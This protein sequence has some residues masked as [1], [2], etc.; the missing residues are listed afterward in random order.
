MKN[1]FYCI[2][3]LLIIAGLNDSVIAQTPQ[4]YNFNVN[5]SNNSFPTNIAG[6]KDVQLLYLAGNFNQPGPAPAGNIVSIALRIADTYP[7]GPW[8]YTNFTIQ[9]GQSVITTFATGTF[10]TGTLT[11]VY[12]HATVTLTGAA[13]QWMTIPLDTPFPYDPT[14]SLIVDIGQCS[15]PAA[16]GYSMCFSASTGLRRN[17]SAGGCPFAYSSQDNSIYHMGIN[18]ATGGP[19]VVVT[20]AAT[21]VTGN[22]ANLNGTVNANG[23]STSVTFDYGLTTSYGTNV[24][25]VPPTV[26]GNTVTP[27]TV[28]IAGLA[29]NTTYHYRVNGVNSFGTT[30]GGDMTF[31]TLG[32]PPTVVTT[33]A[34][35]VT[36]TSATLNG[37]V[38]ANNVSTS[39]SFDYGLNTSYGTNVAGVPPTVTGNVATA[40]LANI[41]GLAGN[42]TYHYRINGTSSNGTT[43][44]NDM[45]FTTSGPPP[46]VVT[47]A[48]TAVTGTTATLNGTVNAN[49]V[50]STVMFEWGPTVAYG[51][52]INGI[53]PTVSGNSVTPVSAPIAGLL[54]GNTYHFRV[55]AFNTN[56]TSYGNDMSLTTPTLAPTVITYA[57]TAIN[58]TVATLN[59]L[60]TANGVSTNIFFDYGLTVA[61]GTIVAGVPPSVAGNTPTQSSYNLTG[62]TNGT[63]YHYRARGVNSNG[64]TNGNDVTFTTGCFSAGPAGPVTGPT[65]VCQG[66]SGYVYSVSPI[67]NASGYIWTLPVGGTITLGA[68]TNTITVSY[69]ASAVSGYVYVYGIAGCGNGSPAQLAVAMNPPAAPTITGPASV[70]VNSTPVVYSTQSGMSAYAWSVSPGG[71]ITAGLGTSTITVS[72]ATVGAKTV[73]VNYNTAAGCSALSPTVYNVTVNALPIPTIAGPSPA[74]SNYPGLIYSTQAGM[75]S[76]NWNISAGG[77]ITAGAGTNTIT[78]TWN[79]IGAQTISVNYANANGCTAA[80]PVVYPVTVNSGAA[81]TI[82]GTTTL[83]VNSGYYN[84]T[85]QAGNSGY[86][87]TISSGGVI[88]FGAGTNVITVTWT[89]SGAQWVRVNYTTPA[90]CSAVSP[91]QYNVTVNAPPAAAGSITGT[92]TVCAGASNVVYTVAPVQGAS[93][94]VWTLPAGATNANGSS[95][96]SIL[97]NFAGNASSGN[98]TVYANNLCGNGATSPPFAVTV[99]PLPADAGTITGP[100]SVCQGATGAVYTVTPITGSTGYA[101]TVPAGATI[102]SGGNTNSIVVD[103]GLGAVSGNIT[104]AGTNAC[105]NGVVSPNFPVTVNAIPTTP[106]VTNT[107]YI[108]HSS[109]PTGNQWWYSA[110]Q[111]GTGAPIAGATAQTYDATLT[112]TGWYWSIV[113]LNGCSSA[114]SNHLQVITTGIGSHSSSAINIYPVP[115]NGQFNVTITTA[116]IESFSISV[117]NSLGV[118]IY[119]EANVEVNGSLEKMIDL[120]PVPNGV[121][122]VI[123]EDSLGQVVKKIVITK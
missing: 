1:L 118:K 64:T 4:Y 6:G 83:C 80:A 108:V 50:S 56:G 90:G 14:Q 77:L 61:Y 107:G 109:A 5:G 41:A 40:S 70:C 66:G 35:N 58:T 99:N 72:W 23:A 104:V 68:N 31:T 117:Y 3:I 123:F 43:N 49:N 65:Q 84:Y 55:I 119:E 45:T 111:T 12:S 91:T 115:N 47:T 114:E 15:V 96:N 32:P 48:A 112:G 73:S 28:A 76:Y 116:S 100:A 82:T 81:P 52:L 39:V 20:T 44:G 102:M 103:F 13:G 93:A 11:T 71:T 63:T 113:T 42:T 18:L 79:A 10:Y 34:T 120:R 21:G 8:V 2:S 105:G 51:T 67:A 36:G 29:N 74:C 97:V 121:Y 27:V 62:L 38:N 24:A 37:T 78:V 92:S 95:T 30:N 33:A 101:W 57:A 122:S 54:P 89:S 75:T 53:P 85:T 26:T 59:G 88:N 110:T 16:S 9:M 69:S 19:P 17:W 86:T 94:Y 25:G 7:L 106:V 22:A 98:I 46:T 60:V 87:W